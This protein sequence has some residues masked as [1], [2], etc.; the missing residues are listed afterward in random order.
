M[1]LFFSLI[2]PQSFFAVILSIP[3]FYTLIVP[4]QLLVTTLP[5]LI[6][7]HNPSGNKYQNGS[8]QGTL[9]YLTRSSCLCASKYAPIL[10]Q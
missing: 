5:F 9:L 8:I 2:L 6:D 3:F 4:L 1:I 10:G 7:L